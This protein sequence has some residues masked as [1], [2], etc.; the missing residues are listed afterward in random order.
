MKIRSL[1][2]SL[3]LMTTFVFAQDT[4]PLVT[5]QQINQQ[6]DTATSW[7]PSPL[8][9]QLV[10]V[11]GQVNV[12][13]I[14]SSTGNRNPI[15]WFNA[16]WGCYIQ[17][18]GNEPWGG[19][20]IYSGD[21]T[22]PGTQATLIDLSDTARTYEF[23]GVVTMYGQTTEL[24]LTNDIPR[25]LISQ[26][27]QRYEP[28]PLTIDSFYTPQGTF[29]IGL[30]KYLGMY[31]SLIADSNHPLIVSDIIAGTGSSAGGFKINGNNGRSVLMY[32]QSRY[33]KTGSLR[34]R[35]DYSPP[36]AGSYLTTIKGILEVYNNQWEIVPCYPED[37]GPVSVSPPAITFV[38]RNTA[39]VAPS[40]DVTVTCTVK[41]L[42][43][44]IVTAVKLFKRVNFANVDSLVMTKGTGAD[45]TT[46]TC[47]IPG[48]NSD[49]AFVDYYVK[50]YDNNNLIS[51]SPQ[52]IVNSRY[53]YFVLNRPV[54]IKD[55]RYSPFGSAY[56]SYH[57]YRVELTGIVTAD[58]SDISGN[59]APSNPNPAR[60][61][62]QNGAGKWSGILLGTAGQQVANLKR[63]DK[64]IVA[65]TVLL[66]SLGVKLDSLTTLT[67]V[68][69]NNPIPEAIYLPIDSV[70]TSILGT[71]SVEPWHQTLVK[72]QN[73]TIDSA[74]ADGTSNFGESFGTETG[75]TKHTRIIWSDGK[76]S[77]NVGYNGVKV[78]K[79][80]RFQEITGV[81]S[82]THN[83]YKLTPRTDADIL[84]YVPVSV[85]NEVDILPKEYSLSQNYPNPFNPSTIINYSIP[86]SGMVTLRIYNVLGQ[87]VK[88]LVNQIQNPGSHRVSFNAS[89][90][91]SGIY[92]YSL[93]AENF[94]QVKKMMLIK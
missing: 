89:A 4:I 3:M 11:R 56:S 25:K 15:L 42:Q 75:G 65:G 90:L 69:S 27:T 2:V 31:I 19:L 51:T 52:N 54:T 6:P 48:I 79:G 45:S 49:S 29:N 53:S 87:E 91:S 68:S 62:I 5:L 63:G 43:G 26:Q 9:G 78:H 77:F 80:D 47:V 14:I 17:S 24:M 86:K 41:G 32:A 92:F 85:N 30:R 36:P 38:K 28:I 61:Y 57:N 13:P 67:V 83:Q 37:L 7:Y 50:A 22:Q 12:R 84:G 94:V 72:Y 18:P 1:F 8:A 64:V 82:Y 39:T 34:E 23:T 60:V 40:Q 81:L 76:T 10:R 44:G 33:F 58:T 21:T 88:T 59:H 35:P 55:V 16:H 74:N 93:T 73:I 70:G 46:F 66:G 71:L 20:N